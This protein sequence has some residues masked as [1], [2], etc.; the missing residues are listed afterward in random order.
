[1]GY[2]KKLNSFQKM[3]MVRIFRPDRVYNATKLF[4]MGYLNE[5][6]I[7]SHAMP[8]D[9]IFA[10]SHEK[11]PIV[12]ILSPGADPLANVQKLAEQVFGAGSNKF[13]F[14]ALGQG[15]EN[16]AKSLIDGGVLKGHWVMLQNCHLLTSWLK[17]L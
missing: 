5:H 4:I 16:D 10:Q 9:Q 11:S 2:D 3:L 14:L 7:Q 17:K 13:R 1:M 8:Y 12:F 6:Y 15:M